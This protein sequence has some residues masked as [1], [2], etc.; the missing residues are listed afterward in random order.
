MTTT[1]GNNSSAAILRHWREA[2]PNDRLAH[3]IKDAARVLNR[4]LQTRLAEH[5]VG[6][7]GPGRPDPAATGRGAAQA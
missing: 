3:L 7:T 1:P 5:G 6:A 4:A 2:V